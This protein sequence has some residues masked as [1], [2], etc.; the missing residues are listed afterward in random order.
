VRSREGD[1]KETTAL[2]A[3]NP[4]VLD[5]DPDEG[6]E[7]PPANDQSGS[8]LRKWA[9]AQA[10]MVKQL[11]KELADAKAENAKRDMESVFTK[12]GVPDKVRKF[13]AGDPTEDAIT[14]WVKDNAD[15]FGL[16]PEGGGDVTETPERRQMFDDLSGVMSAQQMGTD[17][18]GAVSREVLAQQR[19]E[20]LGK[21]NSGLSDLDAALAAIG[22]PNT[23]L[24]APQF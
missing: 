21:K 2:T 17:K 6:Q 3:P 15:V 5:E 24:M 10:D 14:Q 19:A 16:T 11:Q 7:T 1:E 12:L 13:Y 23:P 20:L 9:K 22:V 8:A 18:D 4:F